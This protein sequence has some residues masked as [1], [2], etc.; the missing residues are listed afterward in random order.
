LTAGCASPRRWF[1]LLLAASAA[2][3]GMAACSRSVSPTSGVGGSPAPAPAAPVAAQAAPLASAAGATSGEWATVPMGHVAGENLFWELFFRDRPGLPWRLVTPPGVA[4]NGGL[5]LALR[6]GPS[7]LAGF[8]PSQFLKFSPL[9]ATPDGGRTWFPGLLSAALVRSP[10][11]LA[12]AGATTY[13]LVASSGGEVLASSAHLSA[14]RRVADRAAVGG[15]LSAARCGLIR[16]TA[17]AVAPTGGLM[18]G[19]R[20]RATGAVGIFSLVGGRWRAAGPPLPAGVTRGPVDV[21]RL[22]SVGRA[23]LAVLEVRTATR[24][25]VVAAWSTDGGDHWSTSPALAVPGAG[26]VTSAGF[27]PS[28]AA[29]V[30][31]TTGRGGATLDVTSG[32]GGGWARLPAPPAGAAVVVPPAGVA[33]KP[34][35]GPAAGYEVLVARGTEFMADSLAGARWVETQQLKV[36]VPF[37]SSD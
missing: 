17:V 27:G 5:V 9:A 26:G 32:P 29:Y 13:A 22:E 31:A 28:G 15:S 10:D 23:D 8:L 36:A 34:S 14:W 35:G 18:V 37:G 2:V 11:S 20:C 7:L 19:G 3:V 25:E 16:L 30:L 6:T 12:A 24:R 1:G 33:P 21:L 4:D